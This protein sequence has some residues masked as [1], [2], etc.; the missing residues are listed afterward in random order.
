MPYNNSNIC[1]IFNLAPHYRSAI[2]KLM[3][4]E[5]KCNFYFGDSIDT[6]IKI[7]KVNELSG[8]KKTVENINLFNG[9]KY[10]WQKGVIGLVFKNYKYFILTGDHSILSSWVI[11]FLAKFL[12]KKV[13][14]WLHGLKSEKELHW[15]GKLRVYPFYK[16]SDKLLLYGDYSRKIMINKGFNP[17]KMFCIYNSLDYDKQLFI[18]KG[19][20]KTDVYKNYFNNDLPVLIYIGRIQKIKKIDSI[21]LSMIIL[22]Q[23]SVYCNLIILGENADEISFKKQ[24]IDNGL[25]TNVWIYGPCY[26]EQLIGELIFNADVCVSPGNV[27]LTAMHCFVYGTPVI[28]NNN[29]ETQMPEFEVIEPGINGDFFEEDNV[30]DLTD[31][32]TNWISLDKVRRENVRLS[33]Y[34]IIDDKYNPHYQIDVL[35]RLI[36]VD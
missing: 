26:Q 33:A 10:K 2:Y 36:N 3:D 6:P 34:K 19:L 31:K 27:G 28:T 23:R 11:V 22:K 14:I 13:F 15:K 24:I 18:R 8:Y 25:E 17:K 20:S 1:C 29:F 32:I 9:N 12:N 16:M 5:L 7:M 30:W 35:K 21:L 4:K